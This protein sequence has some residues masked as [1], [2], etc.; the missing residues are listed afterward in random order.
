MCGEKIGV[1]RLFYLIKSFIRNHYAH[2]TSLTVLRSIYWVT[3]RINMNNILKDT[4]SIDNMLKGY[5]C[6]KNIIRGYLNLLSLYQYY[7]KKFWNILMQWKYTAVCFIYWTLFWIYW[8]FTS[9]W[10]IYCV[11]L[12]MLSIILNVY[13][14]LKRWISHPIYTRKITKNFCR[15][16]SHSTERCRNSLFVRSDSNFCRNLQ[17]I[18]TFSALYSVRREVVV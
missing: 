17:S 9:T 13:S 12:I 1:T 3:S 10:S 14:R 4:K 2:C 7:F 6:T 5:V 16:L 15:C 18:V 11:G 8:A